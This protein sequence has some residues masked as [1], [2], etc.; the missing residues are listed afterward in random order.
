[1]PLFLLI[2]M[3]TGCFVYRYYQNDKEQKDR[4]DQLEEIEEERDENPV[5]PVLPEVVN[6]L[7]WIGSLKIK[8]TGISY[9]VMQMTT[10]SPV[11]SFTDVGNWDEYGE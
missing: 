8:G 11:Y 5:S 10:S 1:M 2:F 9:P 6:N 3:V 4:F 7:D